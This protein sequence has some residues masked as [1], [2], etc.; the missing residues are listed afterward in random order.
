MVGFLPANATSEN[1]PRRKKKLI[2]PENIN[3]SG[4]RSRFLA[5]K[6]TN[7][8]MQ[9]QKT[10]QETSKTNPAENKLNARYA[11]NIFKNKI[12]CLEISQRLAKSERVNK[13]KLFLESCSKVVN[14][15]N[16][17]RIANA[18]TITLYSRVTM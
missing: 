9:H 14:K 5:N 18:V 3:G 15:I 1:T 12:S 11:H 8:Q 2:L 16:I 4:W 6:P 17:A 10:H 13:G 7:Q